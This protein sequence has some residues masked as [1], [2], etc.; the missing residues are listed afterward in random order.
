MIKNLDKWQE[1]LSNRLATISE[2]R[3]R[4]ILF[5]QSIATLDPESAAKVLG[6]ILFCTFYKRDRPSRLTAEAAVLALSTNSWPPEH[7]TDATESAMGGSNRLTYL[8]LSGIDSSPQPEDEDSF[9]VPSYHS[10]RPLT[11]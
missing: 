1:R 2:G 5:A 10:E 9:Q 6:N 3:Q 8:F 4:V 11:L 7:R